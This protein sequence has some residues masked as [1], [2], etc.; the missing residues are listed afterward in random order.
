MQS[1]FGAEGRGEQRKPSMQERIRLGVSACLL[2]EEIRYDGQHKLD[3]FIRD[4]LGQYVEFVPVCPEVECGLGIPREA[5]RLV[6]DP[7]APRLVTVRTG[8]DHTERMLAW[9]RKRVKELESE[10]LCGY[11]FKS[12]SPSCGMARVKVY[13][14]NGVPKNTGVGPFARAFMDHFPLLPV[15]EEGRLH[16][17]KLRE[18]FVESVTTLMRRRASG[19]NVT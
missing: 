9:A 15:E 5:M 17:P 8:I 6:G 7:Q 2:G 16:D 18:T 19:S 12:T 4:T 1:P 11:V 10:N 3:R 14:R 13:D